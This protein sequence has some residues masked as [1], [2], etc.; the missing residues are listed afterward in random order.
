MR[1]I[2]K[3]GFLSRIDTVALELAVARVEKESTGEICVSIAPYFWG[4][5]ART[6][7][8]AFARLGVAG[9]RHRNGVLF[10]VVPSRRAFVVI[11]DVAIDDKAGAAFWEKIAADV[12]ARFAAGDFTGGLLAGVEEVGRELTRFFP[13]GTAPDVDELPN[14]AWG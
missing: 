7:R 3:R 9:T 10:F 2:G 6:A 12:T 5:V 1:W 14:I 13:R 4:D 11:G 8:R